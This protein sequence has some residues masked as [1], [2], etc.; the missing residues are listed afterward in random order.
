M[1]SKFDRIK[2]YYGNFHPTHTSP[3][4]AHGVSFRLNPEQATALASRLLS[5]V[6][7]GEDDI[8]VVA[9]TSGSGSVLRYNFK[10]RVPEGGYPGE[11]KDPDDK[12]T[13][14]EGDLIILNP[15]DGP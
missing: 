9:Y 14:H 6:I 12:F 7:A 4:Q 15:E 11:E 10:G 5:A 13:W 3:K 2:K 8:Q 1:S